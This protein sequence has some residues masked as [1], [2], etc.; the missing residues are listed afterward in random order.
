MVSR[1]QEG[2]RKALAPVAITARQAAEKLGVSLSTVYRRCRSSKIQA[3]KN[4][5]G[6]WEISL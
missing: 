3:V 6:R 4:E 5:R 2:I 1:L